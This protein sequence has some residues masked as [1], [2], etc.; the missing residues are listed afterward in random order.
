MTLLDDMLTAEVASRVTR[1]QRVCRVVVQELRSLRGS[2]KVRETSAGQFA[3][4]TYPVK[5]DFLYSVPLC[6]KTRHEPGFI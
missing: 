6:I 2:R 3:A 4:A 5:S 1:L